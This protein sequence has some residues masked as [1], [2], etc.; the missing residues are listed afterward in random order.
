MDD[1][2]LIACAQQGDHQVFTEPVYRLQ[3]CSGKSGFTAFE[4]IGVRA[5]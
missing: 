5:L 3:N 4:G 1:H 2:N